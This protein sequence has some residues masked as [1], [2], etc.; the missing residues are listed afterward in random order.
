[1]TDAELTRALAGVMGWKI[2]DQGDVRRHSKFD[3]S[4]PD[5]YMCS[6]GTFWRDAKANG[7]ATI[8]WRPLESMDDALMI[9]RRFERVG[10]VW[11]IEADGHTG[12]RAGVTTTHG[13][14]EVG[15][16]TE[17]RA[18]CYAA[19]KAHGI[20]VFHKDAADV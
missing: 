15:A 20:D 16:E 7:S 17:A 12:K 13:R 14:F 3:F 11:W 4:G 6:D 1:M 19:L 2:R 5:V 8:P 9:M 18:A 10:C